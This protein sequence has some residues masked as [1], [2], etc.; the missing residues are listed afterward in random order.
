MGFETTRYLLPIGFAWMSVL[1][2]PSKKMIGCNTLSASQLILTVENS[3]GQE[4][5]SSAI[6]L[7]RI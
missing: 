1:R 6:S 5:L 2:T 3:I 4:D 7:F